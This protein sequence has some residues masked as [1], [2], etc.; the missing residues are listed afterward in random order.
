MRFVQFEG[1][2][3]PHH[4]VYTDHTTLLLLMITVPTTL[5]SGNKATLYNTTRT[6]LFS[7]TSV[8]LSCFGNARYHFN[9][10]FLTE[11]WQCTM[12]QH[13][14]CGMS[15][16]WRGLEQLDLSKALFSVFMQGGHAIA[17]K[18]RE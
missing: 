1:C 16:E 2:R 14:M 3:L 5:V 15:L 18:E 7:N 9:T 12:M 6:K 8:L 17:D 13:S 11:L 4:M 10:T